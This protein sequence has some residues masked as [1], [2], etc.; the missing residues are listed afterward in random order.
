MVS[1]STLSSLSLSLLGD[2]VGDDG[3]G[4]R[5]GDLVSGDRRG[6]DESGDLDKENQLY[7][8]KFDLISFTVELSN[9]CHV[10]LHKNFSK[11]INLIC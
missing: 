11:L 7:I 2:R 5:S 6:D 4:D 8:R 10:T 9:S 3:G 1:I